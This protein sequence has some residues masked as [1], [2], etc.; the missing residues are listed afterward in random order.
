MSSEDLVSENWNRFGREQGNGG[1]DR[2]FRRP[3]KVQLVPGILGPHPFEK[4][5]GVH[6]SVE[7]HK[8]KRDPETGLFS[9]PDS[10]Y[11]TRIGGGGLICC[12][13]P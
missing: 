11:L 3:P 12:G 5:R 10:S 6:L 1:I 9:L 7:G 2:R 8:G 4:P 13:Q